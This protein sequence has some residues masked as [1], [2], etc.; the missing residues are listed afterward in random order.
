MTTDPIRV[1]P[2]SAHARGSALSVT[3]VPRAGRSSIEQLAN[4][5]LRVRVAEPPVEGA[6][7]A[8]LLRFLANTLD[9]P[10]SRLAIVS[11]ESSRRKRIV[12]DGMAPDVLGKRLQDA[13]GKGR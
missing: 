11:G 6:A 10:R 13:L 9:V 12:V 4:G 2:V 3:V 8:A 5:A 7:N 1:S